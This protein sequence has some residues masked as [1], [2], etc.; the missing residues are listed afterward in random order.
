[1]HVC[2]GAIVF[3]F[4]EGRVEEVFYC[5]RMLKPMS[6]ISLVNGSSFT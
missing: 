3:E 1:M 5:S 6:A 4:L 2:F